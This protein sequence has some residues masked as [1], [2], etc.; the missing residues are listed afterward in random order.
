MALLY[1][2]ELRP[3][4]LELLEV[5]APQQPW[6]VGDDGAALSSVAAYRFDDP[7]GEVGVETLL[8]RADDG[9]TLQVP[10]TYRSA[11]LDGGDAFLVGTMEHSVLGPRWVYDGAG[12]PAYLQTV[13]CAALNGGQQAELIVEADGKRTERAPSA[14]VTGSGTRNDSVKFPSVSELNVRQDG[15]LTVIDT[16]AMQVCVKRVID[17]NEIRPSAPSADSYRAADTLTGTW[18]GVSEPQTLVL[19]RHN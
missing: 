2:S 1:K 4:K 19:V 16:S 18:T 15:G 6:F 10:L 9:P 11:P 7:D 8:V 12:D 5:W 3:S 13:A 17:G 14:L